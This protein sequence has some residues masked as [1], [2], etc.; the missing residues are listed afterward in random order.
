[1]KIKAVH[2]CSLLKM[3]FAELAVLW[4]YAVAFDNKNCRQRRQHITLELQVPES[5]R[6]RKAKFAATRNTAQ[7]QYYLRQGQ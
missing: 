7:M 1:M 3:R 6:E 2:F 4:L 5:E